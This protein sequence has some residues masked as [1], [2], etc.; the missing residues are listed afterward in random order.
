MQAALVIFDELSR[1]HRPPG[2]LGPCLRR[3]DQNSAGLPT[4]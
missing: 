3:D 2:V 4:G 1:E